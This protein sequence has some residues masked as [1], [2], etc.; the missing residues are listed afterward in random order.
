MSCVWLIVVILGWLLN[1]C[2]TELTSSVL[3]LDD[4]SKDDARSI[5]MLLSS[6]CDD[7]SRDVISPVS[8]VCEQPLAKL[9]PDWARLHEIRFVSMF[10]HHQVTHCRC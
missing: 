3:S 2:I 5:E 8:M 6:F 10:F 4:I 9:V 1:S 7:V